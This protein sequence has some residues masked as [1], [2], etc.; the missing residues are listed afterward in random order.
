[1]SPH[2]PVTPPPPPRPPPPAPP[3]ELSYVTERIIAVRFPGGGDERLFGAHLR[4]VAALLRARHRDG[5]T[6]RLG[7]R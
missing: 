5:Y 4:D 3:A 6:V 1:M 2:D 7:T